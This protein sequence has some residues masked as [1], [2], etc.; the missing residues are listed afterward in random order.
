M[1][2]KML[3]DATHAEETRVVVVDGNK[4]EEFDFESENKR[5]LAGNIYLA[6]VTRVE[7]SLQAAFVDYGGNRHGFLAF[8]EIHPDYY[9]IPVADREALME[10][11]RAYAEAQRA[12]DDEEDAKPARRQSRS[13]RGRTKAADVKSAD[14]VETKDVS[15]ETAENG[16]DI[17]GMETIDLTDEVAV[18]ETK[19]ADVPEA[20]QPEAAADDATTAE[21]V[22]EEAVKDASDT[23]DAQDASSESGE[24]EGA[25]D[26]ATTEADDAADDA[27]ADDSADKDAAADA[28][29]KDENIESVADEDDSEDIRPVRKPRPRRYKIQEVIKVRQV[30]LV[31]VVKEERGNKGAALTTYLSL[32][33]R[34]CVLMPNTAR[35]GGISR[36]I[37]NAA[38]RKKL[39]DIA[40]ELDVPTGAG[41]I[42]RTAGA[43]RTKSEI[44]RDYEYL[45][46]LWEQIRE[47]TLKSIAP[48]KIYEE[49]DL[50]KRSIRDLY[51]REIDEVLVEGERGYRIAKD[52][53]KMIMP[54]H[55][56]NVKNY[57]DQL[58][59]FARFQVESY[60]GAMFNPTVQ[61]KS[62]GYIVIGVTEALVAIDVNSGR[63]TKE[64]SIEETALKTNLEAAEEVA[65]QLRLRDLAGLI[66]IDFI[67]MDERKNNAAVEKRMKD[68]LKTDRARIQVGR[69]SGFGLMEMSRQRLRPGMIEAT[70]APCPHCHGTGLIRS[71]DSL[72]LSI[73]RQIEEEGT[74]RRSRE[75]LV[76][77]PVSIANYLMNQ[78]REHIA[79]IETRYGLSV[80]IEGDP[81]LVSPD[82]SLEKFKTASRVVPVATAPVVSVDTSIMDQVDA[83]EASDEADEAEVETND[84]DVAEV[85]AAGDEGEG[86]NKPKRKRRRR[87]RRKSSGADGDDSN[88]A[89]QGDAN[90]DDQKASDDAAADDA[91]AQGEPAESSDAK[92]AEGD[93]E[94]KKRTRTRTRSRSRKKKT[95]ETVAAEAE[96]P[97]ET[98]AKAE[99]EGQAIVTEAKAEDSNAAESEAPVASAEAPV[100]GAEEPAV[101][102]G[103]A[104]AEVPA[105][106]EAET[107]A[108]TEEAAPA[109]IVAD[110]ATAE[111]VVA[112][113]DTPAAEASAPAAA[114]PQAADAPTEEPEAAPEP[115]LATAE[116]EPASPPKPKRRGWWSVGS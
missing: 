50:I 83:D 71:D 69:I 56:K 48:A 8:S 42:V 24:A 39:K 59:L 29:A 74:R 33:G 52:F 46:R 81:H 82:F 34:Y 20:A 107:A 54:S 19:L 76:R 92:E 104:A 91:D 77:C 38:D 17:A 22:V 79:Q 75:V 68:K 15:P 45:Q 78:K 41:L 106:V 12:R 115:A 109:Q 25:A 103:D 53:M 113:Q 99:P 13:R 37:T 96:A 9:Q 98:D 64:G 63:A 61:L 90:A 55:A 65:R 32:A 62:G 80:R 31:Q 7:P 2:K 51:S 102:N 27:D 3:I 101:L 6:K 57:Q 4:V 97:A 114:E 5:Q 112:D 108:A 30:L 66:V 88:N 47:L 73:L 84:T 85:Q 18:A 16:A 67:D 43:K 11:E 49:G 26:T 100:E 105:A 70:T 36:K 116:A 86:D 14:V 28:T 58:P 44:K 1:A 95:D 23:P 93:G 60:L 87:R 35:G 72:A 94:V 110:E 40:V 10:E 111:D 89:A 21:P